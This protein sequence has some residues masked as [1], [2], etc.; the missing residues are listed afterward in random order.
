MYIL[1]LLFIIF[2]LY[3]FLFRSSYFIPI[4]IFTILMG[5]GLFIWGL[6]MLKIGK[7]KTD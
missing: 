7:K 6:S 1:G 5:I 3:D 4:A 2:S